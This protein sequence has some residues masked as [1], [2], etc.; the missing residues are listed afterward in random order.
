M[1]TEVNPSY[2][3]AYEKF[4]DALHSLATGPYD[5]RQRL[6][7][8]YLHFH[9]V[10]KK[11]LS[12]QLQNDYQWVLD[13]LTRFGP[14]I[15]RDGKVLR[16]TVEETLVRIRNSTVSKI[17]ERILHIYHQLNWLC[18]EGEREP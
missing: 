16:G 15:G 2:F 8:V 12:E 6:R 18:M 4:N 14:V 11:H 5:V 10:R 13:Q 9:P 7:S 1:V 3:Y 17:A